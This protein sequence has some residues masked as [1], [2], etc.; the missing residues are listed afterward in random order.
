M[1]LIICS[2]IGTANISYMDAIK[3]ILKNSILNIDT[4][5]IPNSSQTIIWQ[6]IILHSKDRDFVNGEYE[7]IITDLKALENVSYVMNLK[8]LFE[9]ID[10]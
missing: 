2:C 8:K 7:N 10:K 9:R 6:I 1:V 5:S 4:S 3:I